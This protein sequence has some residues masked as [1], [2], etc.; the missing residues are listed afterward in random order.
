ME[1][2]VEVKFSFCFPTENFLLKE[3]LCSLGF[4][5]EVLFFSS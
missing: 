5:K 3:S 2:M 4:L 1:S